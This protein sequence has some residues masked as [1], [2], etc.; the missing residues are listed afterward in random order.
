MEIA[1]AERP[2]NSVIEMMHF[3]FQILLY[4]MLLMHCYL[5]SW[6]AVLN[7]EA[8][9]GSSDFFTISTFDVIIMSPLRRHIF[10]CFLAKW[11]FFGPSS[12][13]RGRTPIVLG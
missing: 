12:V 11:E 7:F 4:V 6:I 2:T 8:G 13:K 10:V 9:F 5:Y 3:H 1:G